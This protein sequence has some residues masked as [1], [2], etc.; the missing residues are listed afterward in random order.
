M[1]GGFYPRL[2]CFVLLICSCACLHAQRHFSISGYVSDTFGKPLVSKITLM[3]T[4]STVVDTTTAVMSYGSF[5]EIA[6]YQLSATSKGKYII[7][8]S[9]DGY[10]DGLVECEIKSNR[11]GMVFAKEIRMAKRVPTRDLPEL[12]VRATKVKMVMRGDTVVY[13]AD[14]FNLADGSMLDALISRLPGTTLTRDG[15]IFV[16]GKKVESL[17]VNGRDFFAGN[18]QVALQNLPA[19]IVGKIKVYNRMG[20]ASQRMGRDMGD[21]QVVMDVRLKREYAKNYLGNLEG[22]VGTQHRYLLRGMGLKFSDKEQVV[23]FFNLNNLNNNER[24]DIGGRWGDN[25]VE[26]G[27]VATKT[28]GLS[29]HNYLRGQ[30]DEFRGELYYTHTDN[31]TEQRSHTQTFLPMGDAFSSSQSNT[32]GKSHLLKASLGADMGV[33]NL[34]LKNNLDLLWANR[35]GFAASLAETSD[36]ASVLNRM[37]MNS[38]YEAHNLNLRLSSSE[39]LSLWQMDM[40]PFR[41]NLTYDRLTQ[42]SFSLTDAT[43]ATTD[44]PSDYRNYYTESPNQHLDLGTGIGYNYML[45]PAMLSV[46]YEYRYRYNKARNML[47][48]LDKLADADSTRFDVLPSAADALRNVLEA[49]NSYSMRQY[50]NEHKLTLGYSFT[51][52]DRNFGLSLYLP[53]R[54]V[55]SNLYYHREGRH[56]V[57]RSR[58]FVEPVF[59]MWG[60][61]KTKWRIDLNMTSALPDLTAMVDYRDSSNP[62]SIRMGNPHLHDTHTYEARASIERNGNRQRMFYANVAYRQTDHAVAYALTFNKA[63]GVSAIQPVSV[64]GNWQAHLEA[65]MG[66]AIDKAQKWTLNNRFTAHYNHNVDM[67]TVA[68]SGES[69]RSIVNNYHLHNNLSLTFRPNDRYE[70]ALSAGGNYYLVDG[71]R[72]GFSRINAGDYQVALNTTLALPWHLQLSTDLTMVA[73]RGYQAHQMNTSDWVWNAQLSRTFCKGRLL[74][75]LQGYDILHELSTTSYAVDAQGRTETWHNAIPRYA[76]ISLAWRFN[77]NPKR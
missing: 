25:D 63:T 16:K 47:Y 21:K 34:G 56:D 49:P 58:L 33:R 45:N 32:V 2:L 57:S 51:S 26:N 69:Q 6:F 76:M 66:R 41:F 46:D 50:T 29:Y 64:N 3:T 24:G 10:A 65:G 31:D 68:G 13:N 40:V 59:A 74:A 15:Q 8:A 23:G 37:L 55:S 54:Q 72:E 5:G 62:L 61:K 77:V 60:E 20:M 12:T 18:P 52:R 27:L 48:R 43:F 4:D 22:G 14:A 42:R 70:M 30:F 9:M 1:P 73:R 39:M 71:Q 44:A 67:A 35:K 75:K 19:Y 28:M 38:C 17:L 11:Q 7:R 53:M 36:S